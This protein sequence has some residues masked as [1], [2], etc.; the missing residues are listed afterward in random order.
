MIISK[1]LIPF[2]R[3]IIPD[4][5]FRQFLA[6]KFEKQ[7]SDYLRNLENPTEFTFCSNSHIEF[8]LS[9]IEKC[10]KEGLNGDVIECGV[11]KGGS[12]LR[13]A[14]RMKKLRS[15]KKLYALDTF[16]GHPYD[17]LQN[18]PKKLISEVY[19]K[20]I[21]KQLKTLYNDVNLEEI[22]NTFLKENLDNT[23]FLKGL[24][25]ESFKKIEDK[26]FCFAHVDADSYLSVK[27]CIEFLKPRIVH[28][29]IILFDDYN[30][31]EY[32]GCNKAVDDL[33]GSSSLTLLK[34]FKAYWIK[35]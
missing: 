15:R 25:E 2:A 30:M 32:P 13:I 22:K 35:Q 20:K 31:P 9:L 11:Y 4:S 28:G 10:L 8:M 12:C 16:G 33:I 1:L 18:M 6:R 3:K 17:D 21:P 7:Y 24:F 19:D 23:I 5:K 26:K 29:G 34:P 14:K 27:Q